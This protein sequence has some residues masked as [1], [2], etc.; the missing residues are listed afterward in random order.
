MQGEV[1]ISN[2]LPLPED[3]AKSS[4]K[5]DDWQ[6][7]LKEQ[8]KEMAELRSLLLKNHPDFSS[9]S[10]G[11]DLPSKS[12]SSNEWWAYLEVSV[13]FCLLCRCH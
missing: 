10:V 11:G 7:E 9:V 8:L 5:G 1:S 13:E 6:G 3:A 4:V 2:S 12:A